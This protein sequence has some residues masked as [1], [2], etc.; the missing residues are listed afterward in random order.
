MDADTGLCLGCLRTLAEIG[1][2][3][4]APDARKREIWNNIEARGAQLSA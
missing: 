2:W 3:G 4:S 1:Q